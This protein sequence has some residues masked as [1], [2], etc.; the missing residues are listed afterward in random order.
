M[1]VNA[2]RKKVRAH[3]RHVRTRAGAPAC[4]ILV[5]QVAE[6]HSEQHADGPLRNDEAKQCAEQFAGPF[7]R[8]RSSFLDRAERAMLARAPTA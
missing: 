5:V 7:H 8:N 4:G 2:A 6:D 3:G 1:I